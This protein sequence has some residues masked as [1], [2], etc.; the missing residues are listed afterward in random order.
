MPCQIVGTPPV[1]VTCSSTMIRAMSAG[2]MRGPGS[3]WR[4]P[5]NVAA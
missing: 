1:N 5:A 4:A 2:V 3:T